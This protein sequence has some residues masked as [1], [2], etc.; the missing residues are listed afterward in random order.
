MIQQK[1]NKIK[2]S[3]AKETKQL[4]NNEFQAVS[5]NFYACVQLNL[6]FF[7]SSVSESFSQNKWRHDQE[8]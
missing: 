6:Q 1:E 8:K 5:T 2:A 4:K 3:Q 7:A